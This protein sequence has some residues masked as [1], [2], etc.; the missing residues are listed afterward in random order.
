MPAS[1]TFFEVRSLEKGGV[2]S[3][4]HWSLEWNPVPGFHSAKCTFSRRKL[5]FSLTQSEI[6]CRPMLNAPF[7]TPRADSHIDEKDRIYLPRQLN[8][9]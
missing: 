9:L 3:D 6:F 8:P 2:G 1:G 4:I 7:E 5:A